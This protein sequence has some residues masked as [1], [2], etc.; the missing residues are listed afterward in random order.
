[1]VNAHDAAQAAFAVTAGQ[2]VI[3]AVIGVMGSVLVAL[4][5]FFG[6][7]GSV[8]AQL[9]GQLNASFKAL[10]D[11]LVKEREADEKEMASLRGE[12]RQLDQH[13]RSLEE[14]LRRS[15]IEVPPRPAVATVFVLERKEAG[16]GRTRFE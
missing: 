7:R 6:G 8:S 9:Q 14:L 10:T 12:V 16:N 11:K 4:I 13:I 5:G 15:G 1:M 3:L 2:A